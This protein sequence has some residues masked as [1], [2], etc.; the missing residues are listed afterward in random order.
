MIQAIQ[1]GKEAIDMGASLI[2]DKVPRPIAKGIVAILSTV[3]LFSL[4]KSVLSTFVTVTLVGIVGWLWLNNNSMGG[5]N[6]N[7]DSDV[8]KRGN[9]PAVEDDPLEEARRIMSKYK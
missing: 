9:D 8:E 5:E 4:V 7:T 2:P 1:T 3:T 6:S